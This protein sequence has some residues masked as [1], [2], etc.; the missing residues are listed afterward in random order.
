MRFLF[1]YSLAIKVDNEQFEKIIDL[2]ESGKEQGAKLNCGGK[3]VGDKGYFIEPTVFSDVTDD[4]RIAK[5]EVNMQINY[6]DYIFN[7]LVYI[8]IALILRLFIR[9]FAN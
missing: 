9:P 4:M 1:L 2:I 7:I 5:E 3:K 8:F 6:C